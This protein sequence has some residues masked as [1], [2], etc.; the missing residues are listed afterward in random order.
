MSLLNT[1][2]GVMDDDDSPRGGRGG[3]PGRP[4]VPGAAGASKRSRSRG[5]SREARRAQAEGEGEANGSAVASSSSSSGSSSDQIKALLAGFPADAKARD[6][7]LAGWADAIVDVL[8]TTELN[9]G[10]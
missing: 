4:G 10:Y 6:Q 2:S 8:P 1:S 5:R 9:V 7:E 3:R